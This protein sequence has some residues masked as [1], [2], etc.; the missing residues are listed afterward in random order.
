MDQET[1][2]DQHIRDCLDCSKVQEIKNKVVLPCAD[3]RLVTIPESV[4]AEVLSYADRRHQGF[5]EAYKR[6]KTWAEFPDFKR[7]VPQYFFL[8]MD[9]NFHNKFRSNG[10][11]LNAWSVVSG[12]LNSSCLLNRETP[13]AGGTTSSSSLDNMDLER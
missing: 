1:T 5:A 6:V 2:V 12:Q 7:K 8:E 13:S 3:G 11:Q 4:E 10:K 9:L